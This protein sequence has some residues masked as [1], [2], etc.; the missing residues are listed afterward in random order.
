M[1]QNDMATIRREA[2]EAEPRAIKRSRLKYL[3]ISVVSVLLVLL[4]WQLAVVS[5]N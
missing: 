4:A 2:R 5:F 3:T 1:D